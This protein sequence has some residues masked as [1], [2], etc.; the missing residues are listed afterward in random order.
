VA[1]TTGEKTFRW[2][3]EEGSCCMADWCKGS[4]APFVVLASIP[5]LGPS[6][7]KTMWP[8]VP[9]EEVLII[10]DRDYQAEI[11][12]KNLLA[13]RTKGCLQTIEAMKA[14]A[15]NM[16]TRG[17]SLESCRKYDSTEF[18]INHR[19]LKVTPLRQQID[20]LV[21]KKMGEKHMDLTYPKAL[22][23]SLDLWT[24]LAESGA[25]SKREWPGWMFNGGTVMSM[26]HDCPCC[27]LVRGSRG[28]AEKMTCLACPA[29]RVWPYP[30]TYTAPCPCQHEKSLYTVWRQAETPEGRKAAA[31]KIRDG[32]KELIHETGKQRR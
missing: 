14:I 1:E 2:T 22:K 24:W 6:M 23:L 30:M 4:T 18:R 8:D 31:G 5:A 29:W 19:R 12:G 10:T 3:G 20:F 11:R 27:E 21:R 17:C 9:P 25:A 32:L 15:D 26:E 28:R 13:C 16:Q 7:A